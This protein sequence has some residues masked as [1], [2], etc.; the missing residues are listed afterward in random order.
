MEAL[1]PCLQHFIQM[2]VQHKVLQLH[3]LDAV[4]KVLA[5]S[6]SEEMEQFGSAKDVCH[7]CNTALQRAGLEIRGCQYAGAEYYALTPA[8]AA[9]S[10]A[11]QHASGFDQWQIDVVNKMLDEFAAQEENPDAHSDPRRMRQEKIKNLRPQG[12]TGEMMDVLLQKLLD[13]KWLVQTQNKYERPCCL[14]GWS[15]DPESPHGPCA[16]GPCSAPGRRG[17]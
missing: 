8:N 7:A 9:D 5:E 15:L 11:V 17:G 16:G 6:F 10:L 4:H 14:P 12:K 1:T 13:D 3:Q 2:L